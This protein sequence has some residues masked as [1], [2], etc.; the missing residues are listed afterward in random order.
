MVATKPGSPGVR[1]QILAFQSR[2]F[3]AGVCDLVV[4]HKFCL[5]VGGGLGMGGIGPK[6]LPAEGNV[7]HPL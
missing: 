1:Q 3:V 4:L 7:M 6:E 2:E 5:S